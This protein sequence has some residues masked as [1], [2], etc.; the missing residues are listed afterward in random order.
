MKPASGSE[1]SCDVASRE[2]SA[3]SRISREQPFPDD[4]FVL[5]TL[6]ATDELAC[7]LSILTAS[8]I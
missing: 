7:H 6:R 8:L 4:P 1:L 2:V 3:Y 5:H